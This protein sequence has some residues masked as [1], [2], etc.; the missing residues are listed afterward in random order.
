MT[1]FAGLAAP[2]R[3]ASFI[4]RHRLVRYLILPLVLNAGVAA[5]VAWGALRL[6]ERWTGDAWFSSPTA[7]TIARGIAVVLVTGFAFIALQPLVSAPFVD[8]LTEKVEAA[9]TGRLPPS[10]GFWGGLGQALAH[11]VLKTVLYLFALLVSTV[12]GALTGIG[13]VL[14]LMLYGAFLAYDGFDYPLARRGVGFGGKWRYLRARPGL[15]VGYAASTAALM[16]V[17][18]A[19]FVVPALAAAGATL[20][21]LDDESRA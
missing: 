20:A 12:L 3:G 15:V 5:A 21:F 16:L 8:L 1:L 11:G 4:G 7:N 10:A 6:L 13:G 14:G 18:L 19:I 2:F 9:K 17:P